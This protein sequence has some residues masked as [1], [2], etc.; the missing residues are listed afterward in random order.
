MTRH[1]LLCALGLASAAMFGA[2]MLRAQ[3]Q[4]QEAVYVETQ[5]EQ[6]K[7]VEP[8]TRGPV[9][10][11]FA[12]PP[13]DGRPKPGPVVPKKPPEAID[14]L[15]PE[16]KPEGDNVQWIPG[17][18]AWDEER[19]DFL[20]VS[21]F[22]R[23]AP[24]ER[25]WVPGSWAKVEGG[26]QWSNGY[27]GAAGRG[28]LDYLPPPPELPQTAPPTQSP[29]DDYFYVP[30]CWV[31]KDRYVYR[32]GYWCEYRP[33]YVYQPPCY[34]NTP[35]GYSFVDGYWDYPLNG[36]GLLCPPVYFS[37]PVYLN[38]GYCWTPNF[39]V[40]A[41]FLA[42]CLFVNP[43]RNGYCFGDYFGGGFGGYTPF[44][45]YKYGG[46]GCDPFFNYFNCGNPGY[47]NYLFGLYGDR[48]AGRFP[49]PPR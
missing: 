44:C 46:F 41:D 5:D 20:W 30:G 28:K 21:G 48:F 1:H 12:Q 19:K 35:A 7:G 22:W 31:W 29:G 39:C 3:E 47:G 37:Q 43:F 49:L 27:W 26:Y 38:P 11:A 4:N 10:E 36:R 24:P 6:E 25:E 32:P 18:W 2:P 16:Q 40:G 8:Q 14:E 13:N 45:N 15:P 17:Y 42:S 9:H 33:G 23:N 34:Y